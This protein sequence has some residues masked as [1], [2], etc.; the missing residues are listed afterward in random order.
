MGSH[1]I[2]TENQNF[3]DV[4]YDIPSSDLSLTGLMNFKARSFTAVLIGRITTTSNFTCKNNQDSEEIRF[5]ESLENFKLI[6]TQRSC[7]SMALL[8]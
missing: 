2:N 6:L 4:I 8:G 3:F 7:F 5:P 1:W